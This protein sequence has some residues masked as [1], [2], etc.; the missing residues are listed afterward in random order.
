MSMIGRASGLAAAVAL[1]ATLG[2][3]CGSQSSAAS[4]GTAA[5]SGQRSGAGATTTAPVKAKP[6]ST[7][8]VVTSAAG[9]GSAWRVV[10]TV[11]GQPVAW[12][13][14]RAGLTLLRFDQQH[15]R[16]ALHAGSAEPAGSGWHF[17][18]AIGPSEVHH[19]IAGFN[20]GFKLSYGSVGF[21]S[22]GR[23]ATP[24]SSGL[25]SIVTYRN[26]TTQI[27]TWH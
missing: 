11:A 18:S 3:G 27:G 8:P 19:V 15:T 10:A 20:G 21:L 16:L 5:A 9:V 24:L 22:Y 25:G 14:Q 1:L 13:A 6:V 7:T 17:G 12:G 4:N 26:G 2:G 23:V